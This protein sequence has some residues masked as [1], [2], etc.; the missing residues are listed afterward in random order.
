MPTN[1]NAGAA[2]AAYATRAG[3][4]TVVLCPSDTPEINVREIAAQGA[5]VYRVNGLIDECGAI[6]G[7]GAA[8][9]LWFDFSTLKEPYRIEGK[10]T[11]G[12]ELTAQL[13]WRLP[14]AIFYPT[15][16]GTGLIGMWKA[17]DELEQLGWIGSVRPKMFAGAG[18][19]PAPRSCAPSNRARSM[20]NAGK[21]HTR[22]QRVFACPR[23]WVIS[24][25]FARCGE[26]GG[27]AVAVDEDEII[28]ATSDSAMQ[29]GLLLCPE[30]GATLAAYR[31]ALAEGWVA[32]DD[33]A[34]LFNCATGLKY[35][36]EDRSKSIDKD[37]LPALRT[38]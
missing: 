9:G 37:A 15:G 28:R 24:S 4:E 25:S 1:G 17:F 38:L 13:N 19:R 12:L 10:K 14:K 35:T 32:A 20:P 34:V 27:K 22:S 26:S 29:D 3:I 5:R 8:E 7:Q 23:R 2:L 36:M 11:M 31:K 21:M 33:E 30:G 18:E 6:V 16:G